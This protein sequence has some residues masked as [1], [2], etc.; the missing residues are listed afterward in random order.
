MQSRVAL[1]KALSV[2]C[3]PSPERRSNTSVVIA[4]SR[5]RFGSPTARKPLLRTGLILGDPQARRQ[6]APGRA[7]YRRRAVR[8]PPP[9]AHRIRY[10]V[11]PHA[12]QRFSPGSC[13]RSVPRSACGSRRLVHRVA[14]GSPVA[15]PHPWGRGWPPSRFWPREGLRGEL[16]GRCAESP[17]TS[18]RQIFRL[19]RATTAF[20]RSVAS[21]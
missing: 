2:H 15:D 21:R 7:R 16:R 5:W 14:S 13:R 17:Q 12:G 20:L 4:V 3:T 10:P 19:R 9:P 8:P 1:Q 18:S 11:Q 6:P